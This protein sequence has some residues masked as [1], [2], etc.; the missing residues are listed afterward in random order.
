[1]KVA[2]VEPGPQLC[3]KKWLFISLDL[4]NV[5]VKLNKK[6]FSLSAFQHI[7]LP[8]LKTIMSYIYLT[9]NSH[10]TRHKYMCTNIMYKERKNSKI[11]FHFYRQMRNRSSLPSP[12]LDRFLL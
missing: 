5:A 3:L 10:L 1:M 2:V 6:A 4:K 12:K 7:F 9:K 11:Y 8:S